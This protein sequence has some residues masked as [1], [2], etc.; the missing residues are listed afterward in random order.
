MDSTSHRASTIF[1]SQ[2]PPQSLLFEASE[3]QHH[4]SSSAS[5]TPNHTS[6]HINPFASVP[7]FGHSERWSESLG[8]LSK[9]GWVGHTGSLR[10]QNTAN[11]KESLD[12]KAYL[13]T[14]TENEARR[15]ARIRRRGD[16]KRRR[17][18]EIYVSFPFLPAALHKLNKIDRSL[19]IFR[20][21]S[22]A[23]RSF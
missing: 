21:S 10:A 14:D 17:K 12:E 7:H 6:P 13:S 5:Q 18:T 16:K 3:Q 22:L 20:H 2:R 8:D 23:R 1:S 19:A 15:D 11:D 9:N 4:L